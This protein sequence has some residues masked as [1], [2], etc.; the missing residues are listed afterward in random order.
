MSLHRNN[1]SDTHY[2]S[3]RKIGESWCSNV[4]D[5]PS[6][7]TAIETSHDRRIR[8]VC[9]RSRFALEEGDV[10]HDARVL[11]ASPMAKPRVCRRLA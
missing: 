6:M 1:E 10:D 4:G 11:L 7:P 8:C 2:H 5:T 3:Y 9:H